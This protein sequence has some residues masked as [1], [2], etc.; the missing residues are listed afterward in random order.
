MGL[1]PSKIKAY[2]RFQCRFLDFD[3]CVSNEIA[4]TDRKTV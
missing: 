2:R 3:R 4:R 1:K